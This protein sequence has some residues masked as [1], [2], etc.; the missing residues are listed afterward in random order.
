MVAEG[1]PISQL[2][3]GYL[4]AI[5]FYQLV[6]WVGRE[7]RGFRHYRSRIAECGSQRSIVHSGK[8]TDS[9]SCFSCRI[10]C[11]TS[12]YPNPRMVKSSCGLAGS[13]SMRVRRRRTK[14]SIW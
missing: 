6:L 7:R 10:V 5:G 13:I 11:Q 9:V 12:L 4:L 8:M 1:E 14:F 2:T 3:I